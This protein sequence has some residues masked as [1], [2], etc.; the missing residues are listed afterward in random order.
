MSATEP[1]D[2]ASLAAQLPDVPDSGRIEVEADE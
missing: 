1:G 2:A